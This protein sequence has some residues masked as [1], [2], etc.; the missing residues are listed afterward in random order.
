MVKNTTIHTE[1]YHKEPVIIQC[2]NKNDG[3][4]LCNIINIDG[5]KWKKRL[6]LSFSPIEAQ[7][8]LRSNCVL[9][10]AKGVTGFIKVKGINLEIRPKF[11]STDN[12][13]WRLAL[14]RI[15]ALIDHENLIDDKL[16]AAKES[17]FFLA[18]L[19][20]DRF[21]F[22]LKEGISLGLPR[23]Y[24]EQSDVLGF[25]RGRLDI[26]RIGEVL[27]RPD[28]IPCIFEAYNE[29]AP[30][31]RLLKWAAIELSKN[32]ISPILSVKLQ[33]MANCMIDVSMNVPSIIEAD[34]LCLTPQ[35]AYLNEALTIARLVLRFQGIEHGLGDI[36]LRG[37]LWNSAKVFEKFVKIVVLNICKKKA[38]LNFFDNPILLGSPYNE[39]TKIESI[40]TSPDIR[41]VETLGLT[42]FVLDAKYKVWSLTQGHPKAED[43]YQVMAGARVAKCPIAGLIYPKSNDYLDTLTWLIHESGMP[44]LLAAIFIN[45]NIMAYPTGLTRIT[46]KL[47]NDLTM[48]SG[49]L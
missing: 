18:D 39:S 2:N 22:S 49:F 17:K 47:D 6:G 30:I 25:L 38:H 40:Y 20:A 44:L 41:I 10:W 15:L 4:E 35:Y 32:V 16:T 21:L 27:V 45:I 28:L 8:H 42:K 26:S 34:N 24:N 36:Q 29:D 13:H 46:E 7:L 19:M 23:Y 14:V 11:L 3:L 9:L 1:E 31:N 12:E 33:E 43:T 5:Q 48:L 37:L